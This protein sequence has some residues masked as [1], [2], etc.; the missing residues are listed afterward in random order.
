ML[1]CLRPPPS[2]ARS[3]TRQQQPMSQNARASTRDS[4]WCGIKPGRREH[5]LPNKGKR[6]S[7]DG[8]VSDPKMAIFSQGQG[9]NTNKIPTERGE[10]KE[11]IGHMLYYHRHRTTILH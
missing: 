1:A 2:T 7:S 8:R 3:R 11:G 6:P 10:R 5:H 9:Q 4:W